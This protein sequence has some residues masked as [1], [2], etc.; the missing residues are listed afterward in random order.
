MKNVGTLKEFAQKMF[1]V[2]HEKKEIYLKKL[3]NLRKQ[4]IYNFFFIIFWKP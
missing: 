3:P 2:K 1:E 4:I